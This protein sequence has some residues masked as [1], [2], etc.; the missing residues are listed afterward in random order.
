MKSMFVNFLI[1][2]YSIK[3]NWLRKQIERLIRKIDGGF[4]WSKALRK[5]YSSYYGVSIGM[6]SYG[7]FDITRFPK[8]TQIGNYCSIAGEVRVFNAN[9][10]IE[11][12]STHPF[13]YAKGYAG[14]ENEKITRNA[15][16][17]GHDVWIGYGTM[18]LNGCN[19]IGNGAIIGAGSVV[20]KDIEPYSIYAGCP[21]KLIRKRFSNDICEKIEASRWWEC[22]VE[23]LLKYDSELECPEQFLKIFSRIE[24]ISD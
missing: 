16:E 9:H 15:I 13:L 5:I 12:V 4:F 3:N 17:I 6:G 20:T 2:L 10:P 14:R 1:S 23:E 19:K 11:Y 21:A 18:I 7:C 24:A 8:G 22:S